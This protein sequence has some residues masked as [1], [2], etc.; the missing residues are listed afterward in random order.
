[1]PRRRNAPAA[2]SRWARPA[3]AP[4]PP[5][6]GAPAR[7]RR[8]TPSTRCG[9]WG[10]GGRRA[11]PAR[12]PRVRAEHVAGDRRPA[13]RRAEP[14]EA[15]AAA[16]AD[17]PLQDLGDEAPPGL[18]R[19]ADPRLGEG[20][21]ACWRWTR[22]A[23]TSATPCHRRGIARDRRR[24]RR[25]GRRADA[26][27]GGR[28][29]GACPR[30]GRRRRGRHV[31]PGRPGRRSGLSERHQQRRQLPR[32][33]QC[34][35]WPPLISSATTPSRSRARRRTP[36][37]REEPVVL[38]EDDPRRDA[39]PGGRRP[40]VVPHPARARPLGRRDGS[41]RPAPPGRHGRSLGRHRHPP[42]GR[43]RGAPPPTPWRPTTP[44]PTPPARGSWDRRAQADGRRSG[45]RPAGR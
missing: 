37:R 8:T 9:S 21:C 43:R 33:R 25:P 34:R 32:P 10:A 20:A 16:V 28:S 23:R 22:S 45:Q 11:R 15:W 41:P 26:G 42:A 12:P 40:R 30:G 17:L 39:G 27:R 1:M 31:G 4:A 14:E 36:T 13:G 2:T 3:P 7:T 29:A 6:P 38:R 44:R 5:P 24:A 35:R 18:A 19:P